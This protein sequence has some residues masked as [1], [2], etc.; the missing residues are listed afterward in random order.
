MHRLSTLIPFVA[1]L[2]LAAACARDRTGGDAQDPAAQQAG[3][4]VEEYVP[5]QLTPAES[6]AAVA[7]IK[8]HSDSV[9]QAVMGPDYR[10]PAEPYVDTPEKQYASCMAQANS[11]EEPVRSTILQACERFKNRQQ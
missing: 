2:V 10:P 1:T 3:V 4:E 6:T 9:T 11:V 7:K 8:A 5:P